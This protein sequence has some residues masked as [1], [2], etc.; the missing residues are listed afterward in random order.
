VQNDRGRLH[1]VRT[2]WH[3]RFRGIILIAIVAV[4]VGGGIAIEHRLVKH[5]KAVAAA[6]IAA[7]L[8]QVRAA[9]LFPDLPIASV[10]NGRLPGSVA[11]DHQILLG[12]VGSDIWHGPGDP[13]DELWMVTDRGPRGRGDNG[14]DRQAFAIPEYT[15][16]ILHVRLGTVGSDGVGGVDVL[17]TI[18]IV[19]Q[20]GRP[21]T[22]L[23]NIDG[24]DERPVDYRAKT[25][26]AY[27]PS[28]L[29]P[30]G[31][32]RTP[33]GELWVADEYGPSL[34]H[35]DANGTVLKR[36]VPEGVAL[37]GAD[38]P[39]A[40]VLPAI[41][42]RR[43]GDGGFEGLTAS[44]DGGTLYL[45]MQGPLSNPNDGAAERS[46]NTRILVFDVASEQVT[47]E[48]IY[49]FELVR[50]FDPSRKADPE[51]MKISALALA[52]DGQL[53]VLERTP[54][55]ARLYLANPAT[56][57][58]VLGTRWD[59]PVTRPTLESAESLAVVNILPLAK[60]LALDL[61]S[62]PGVPEKLE[63]LA[64]LDPSTVVVANDNDFDVGKFN[65]KGI[66]DGKGDKSMVVT[67]ALNE[68]L[69]AAG[70]TAAPP[71]ASDAPTPAPAASPSPQPAPSSTDD[72]ESAP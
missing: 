70:T 55:A 30:E 48:Y 68:P 4:L 34:V 18:P 65:G 16:M 12:S 21:V 28:G 41:F 57:T 71:P 42:A 63:G 17:E 44:P 54:N 11:D 72:E 66:N 14:N 49:R 61:T 33:N 60:T 23:P 7:P 6:P 62:F 51:D 26:L 10:Q 29:D 5:R 3:S 58:N 56:A 64:I 43:S 53:L 15:P 24:R 2:L 45:A 67:I 31:L 46:R 37:D 69:P 47:A 20:S 36:F 59:D 22:G 25:K 38:Y 27:N 35:L 13:P 50:T 1:V 19:G 39:V 8:G 52:E 32:A 40:P 9:A